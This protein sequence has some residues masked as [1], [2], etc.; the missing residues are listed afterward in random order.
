MGLIFSKNKHYEVI[1]KNI[2]LKVSHF[3]LKSY[4][5]KINVQFSAPQYQ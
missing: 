2:I 5:K 3:N 1:R 4:H